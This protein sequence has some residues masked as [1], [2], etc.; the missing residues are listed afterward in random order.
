MGQ[1]LRITYLGK[2]YTFQILNTTSIS[3]ERFEIQI[4][5]EG[6]TRTLVKDQYDWKPVGLC[7]PEDAES[8][9]LT[10]A[11]G[12]AIALRFRI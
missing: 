12:K 9:G 4:L 8:A 1:P 5:L 11:I 3:S 7:E 10:Q 2:D 6:V